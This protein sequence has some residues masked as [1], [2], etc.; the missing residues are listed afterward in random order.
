MN[1]YTAIGI[2]SGTSLDGLDIALV[3]FTKDNAWSFTVLKSET[4]NY[5]DKLKTLLSSAENLSAREFLLFHNSYGKYIG[6][7]V[8][9]FLKDEEIKPSLIASHGHTIFH[10]A[11]KNFTFQIGNGAVIAKETGITT[12]SDFRTL[13]IALNG[14]GAP[15]VPIGDKFLFSEYDYCLN[16]GGFANISFQKNN[17]RIA[18]DI[19][20]ANI[21]TNYLCNKIDR[22]YDNKGGI[23]RSGL[24]NKK[25]LTELNNIKFYL[26][27]GPKSLGKEWLIKE[28]IPIIEKYDISVADILRTLYEHIAIQIACISNSSEKKKILVTG[29]G[30]Y[31]E[32]L[33]ERIK[34]HSKNNIVL[35]SKNIIDFKEAIIFAFL[36]ILRSRNEINTLSSVTG[37]LR[38]SSGGVIN[39]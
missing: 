7:I 37:A 8:N 25:L 36:G 14:Q 15:L 39:Y 11:E 28:F 23:G 27:K 16:I 19:C 20:P 34:H 21:I 18:F 3:K 38:D 12:V 5:S 29:G 24:V 4:Y 13:D 17:K 9:V 26:Q 10:Q 2:M 22:E 35:P 32:F 31:N 1:N 30:A 33:I 6:E